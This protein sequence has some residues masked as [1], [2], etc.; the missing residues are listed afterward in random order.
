MLRVGL[1]ITCDW[2][3]ER[4]VLDGVSAFLDGLPPSER[5][6]SLHIPYLTDAAAAQGPFDGA[7]SVIF[8]DNQARQLR[9]LTPYVV[10]VMSCDCAEMRI[11]HVVCNDVAIGEAAARELL[12]RGFRDIA[13]ITL[14][15]GAHSWQRMRGAR[16]VAATVG[17]TVHEWV[18]PQELVDWLRQLPKPVG[19]LG[20]NDHVGKRVLDACR[21]AGLHVPTEVAV[22]G[23]D[24]DPQLCELSYPPLASINAGHFEVGRRAAERL[25]TLMMT[26]HDEPSEREGK[27][28][29][30]AGFPEVIVRP[31]VDAL[32]VDDPLVGRALQFIAARAHEG[33]GVDDVCAEMSVGRRS[34]E[35]RFRRATGRTILQELHRARVT[36][37]RRLLATR[38]LSVD[39]VAGL[40][41]FSNQTRLGVVF[42]RVTGLTPTAY[43]RRALGQSGG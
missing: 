13:Y 33:I 25:H 31:S 41:G 37:A 14:D 34:L 21:V 23:V 3:C 20:S 28:I 30:T 6:E 43:R 26:G 16:S 9:R 36:V 2:W 1:F 11:P 42:R 5:W 29:E 7:L 15:A 12:E 8:S 24:N 27:W 4:E 35:I 39:E 38:R 17:A 40:A 19:V 18:P 22:L 32:A 10:G